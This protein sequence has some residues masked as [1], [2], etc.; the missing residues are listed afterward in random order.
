VNAPNVREVDERDTVG[1]AIDT[2][3]IVI[4]DHDQ[5]SQLQVT[6]ERSRFASNTFLSTTITKVA[7]SIVVLNQQLPIKSYQLGRIRV[8]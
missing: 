2:D 6:G 7:V 3:M 1:V 8:C 5:I 4:I